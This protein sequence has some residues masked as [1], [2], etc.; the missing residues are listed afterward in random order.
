MR[1]PKTLEMATVKMDLIMLNVTLM[2]EIVVDHVSTNNTA[3]LVLV[4]ME[5][6]AMAKP[7]HGLEMATVK[8]DLTMLN[9]SLMVKIVVDLL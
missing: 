9:V 6:W 8:M 5:A 1:V 4:L 7:I 3:P 2:V